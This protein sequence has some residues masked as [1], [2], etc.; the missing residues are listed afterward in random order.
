MVTP[1]HAAS[2]EA[3]VTDLRAA[4]AHVKAHPELAGT[5]GAA[6]YGLIARFP[7]RGMIR[8]NVLKMM[9]ELYGPEGRMPDLDGGRA[10][11]SDPLVRLG[12]Q[13]LPYWERARGVWDRL[14]GR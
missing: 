11:A 5:G 4:T 6:M 10:A 7:L 1:A 14:R 3:Y 2:A 12:L 8:Q 9:R 13:L